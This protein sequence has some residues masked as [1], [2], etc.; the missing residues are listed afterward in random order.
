MSRTGFVYHFT[1]P[2]G[3]GRGPYRYIALGRR[4]TTAGEDP[5]LIPF[6]VGGGTY[7]HTPSSISHS[8]L[9]QENAIQKQTLSITLPL[10]DPLAVELAVGGVTEGISLSVFVVDLDDPADTPFGRAVIW[11]G[12]VTGIAQKDSS[13]EIATESLLT[14]LRKEGNR[15]RYSRTCRH[16]LYGPGCG[17]DRTLFQESKTVSSSL[18]NGQRLG[19]EDFTGDF[20]LSG[21]MVDYAGE[22]YY[23]LDYTDGVATLDRPSGAPS[24]A[25]VV[26]HPGCERTPGACLRF[27]NIVNYGGF[28]FIP[29]DNPFQLTE[30]V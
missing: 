11:R 12:R 15:A 25:S 18:D 17:I 3:S 23:I 30:L 21:G 9:V 2:D 22:L 10:T 13:A 28:P 7:D 29:R 1:F 24:G 16:A 4:I 27:N 20:S 19:L 8:R 14:L 6:A 5:E 26:V